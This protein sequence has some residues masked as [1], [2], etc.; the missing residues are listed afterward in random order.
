MRTKIPR[1]FLHTNTPQ[2]E[3]KMTSFL[4][5]ALC[6]L[7]LNTGVLTAPPDT[8]NHYVIDNEPIENFDGSQLVGRKIKSYTITVV[9]NDSEKPTMVYRLH[10]I[11]TDQGTKP[12]QPLYIIDGKAATKKDLQELDP[13][14]IEYLSIYKADN[15]KDYEKYG[16][17]SG[18]VVVVK[19]KATGTFTPSGQKFKEIHVIGSA[20]Q[21]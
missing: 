7:A 6:A 20:K 13:K 3:T 1:P 17:T 14:S 2:I 4:F 10:D 16:N 5:S 8:V 19:L 9:T 12:A 15:A 11:L 21:N 18:G